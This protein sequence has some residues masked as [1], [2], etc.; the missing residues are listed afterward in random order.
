MLTVIL[1]MMVFVLD[2][3]DDVTTATCTA[4]VLPSRRGLRLAPSEA[5][6]AA[7]AMAL[8]QICTP[9]TFIVV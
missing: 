4:T 6:A 1:T 8:L 3:C 7:A 5:S 9:S 2:L